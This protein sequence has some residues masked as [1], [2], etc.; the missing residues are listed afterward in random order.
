MPDG[1]TPVSLSE[2]RFLPI[3]LS[4]KLRTTLHIIDC[5]FCAFSTSARTIDAMNEAFL[6]HVNAVHAPSTR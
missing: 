6:D 2:V 4:A 3:D 1:V 5:R